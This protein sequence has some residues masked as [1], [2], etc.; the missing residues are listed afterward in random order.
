MGQERFTKTLVIPETLKGWRV[1]K[2]VAALADTVSR[3]LIH[4]WIKSDTLKVNN[5]PVKASYRVHAGDCIEVD[6]ELPEHL[7]WES[8]QNVEF[9]ILFEDEHIIVLD[10]PAGL[11]THPGVGNRDGTLVNGLLAHR[12]SLGALP[13]AG[14]VHRLDKGTSGLLVVATTETARTSLTNSL[15][16][17]LVSRRYRCVCEG[18]LEASRRVSLP[19][20]RHQVK[21]TK[22]QVRSDGREAT[23]D[24]L[25]RRNYR[26]HTLIEAR[27][28]TGRTHQIR[29][30]ASAVGLPLVGDRVYGA[31]G[32]LPKTPSDRLIET[33]ADFKRPALHAAHLEFDHPI[34]KE[35]LSFSCPLPSDMLNLL[36]ALDDDLLLL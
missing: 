5:M 17:R 22:Q 8:G 4:E 18:I 15:A 21:R 16:E 34:S 28:H 29:V 9:S 20:G 1:D 33:I 14:I 19:I 13:R 3:T 10:K 6:G 35:P 12:P 11:V 31:R 23:T 25:P 32:K 7:D 36:E 27:L 26:S 24:L 30:H 2:A